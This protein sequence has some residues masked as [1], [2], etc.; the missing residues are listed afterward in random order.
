MEAKTESAKGIINRLTEPASAI[1]EPERRRQAQL[2][3][4]LLLTLVLVSALSTA[5][6]V[7]VKPNVLQEPNTIIAIA[8]IVVVAG[9]YGLS[10][11]RHYG[12]SATVFIGTLLV[13]ILTT[14]LSETG[15]PGWFYYALLPILLSGILFSFQAMFVVATISIGSMLSM[16]LLIPSIE[17]D[18]YWLPVMYTIVMTAIV[19]AFMHYRDLV[20]KDHQAELKQINAA[21]Q[22]SEARWRS[23]V[24]NAP[25]RIVYTTHDG[26]I[27][28]INRV[29]DESETVAS[30]D[31]TVGK[32]IH[33]LMPPEYHDTLKRAINQVLESG[34][35]T[36]FETSEASP[37]GDTAWYS[38]QVGPVEHKG[39][40]TSLT[41]ITSDATER[42]RTEEERKRLQQEIIA[43]QRQVLQELSTPIIPVM[44]APGGAGGIIVMP[45]VGSIDSMRAKDIMRALLAGIRQYRARV[46]ILDITGVPIVDSG[47]A[48][49]LNKTI[50]A[51]H[52]KGARTIITGI[53]DAVA[54]AVVD[55][56]ID[57]S[58]VETLS[59]LQTGLVAA[60][61]KIG[62]RIT[63]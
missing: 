39:Q 26:V 48:A 7:A 36:S 37:D 50:Q 21:L 31:A 51:A 33:D 46:V 47:V 62:R 16:I 45:L 22:E 55:L 20:E 8:S 19:I 27:G 28:F 23:L 11:S 52:L 57:W 17:P 24:Q 35:S 41:F 34:E 60:L 43:S 1:Q 59:D 44:D 9:I 56:G 42:V 53:S 58:G 15:G 14:P 10:R 29:D 18:L 54:E 4:L 63:E 2:L 38:T 6:D 61:A 25:A 40:V 5:I 3:S 12:V 32:T 30:V 13:V 49:H